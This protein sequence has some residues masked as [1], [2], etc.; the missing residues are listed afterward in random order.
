MTKIWRVWLKNWVCHALLNFKIKMGIAGS[1]FE[2]HPPNFVKIHIFWISTNDSKTIFCWLC[3]HRI[4]KKDDPVLRP[5][6]K[7]SMVSTADYLRGP[8]W[9]QFF[10]MRYVCLQYQKHLS[11]GKAWYQNFWSKPRGES[12]YWKLLQNCIHYMNGDA[13]MH[14]GQNEVDIFQISL[15]FG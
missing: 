11:S 2:L 4:W 7:E 15:L 3:W 13:T 8:I 6:V 12:K 10:S 9:T 14:C 5:G 1:I